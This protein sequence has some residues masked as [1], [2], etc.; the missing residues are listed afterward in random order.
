MKLIGFLISS[1]LGFAIGHYLLQGAAAAYASVLI[2]FHVYLA[3]LLLIED[4][5][6]GL[7]MPLGQTILS[8]GAILAFLTGL[9]YARYYIP[10]FGLISLLV[11]ALAPFEVKWLFN[12][13][14]RV[15]VDGARP[16]SIET[17]TA[18]ME[19]HDAFRAYLR[20]EHRPFR[21]TGRSVDEEFSH[22]MADRARKQAE[23]AAK[24][25][26]AASVMS[27][28]QGGRF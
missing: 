15:T 21:K 8:H 7:S 3:F 10:F 6:F 27:N 2:S 23:A 28:S 22:W 5:K 20:Q 26:A 18:T 24:G 13:K 16:A 19:D 11:P 12:A 17:P 4:E 25:V 1:L 14:D 9:A